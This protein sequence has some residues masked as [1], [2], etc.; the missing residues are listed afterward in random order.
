MLSGRLYLKIQST[1]VDRAYHGVPLVL[2]LVLPLALADTRVLADSSSRYTVR[3]NLIFATV[4]STD[5]KRRRLL[6]IWQ[7]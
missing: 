4:E 7:H 1:T 3:Y 6:A 2:P 5:S